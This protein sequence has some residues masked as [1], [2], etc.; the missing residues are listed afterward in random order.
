ML[1]LEMSELLKPEKVI[2][3]SSPK[4]R[5]ELP[6]KYRFMRGVASLAQLIFEPD[7]KKERKTCKAMLKNKN[8]KFM[9]RSVNMLVNWERKTNSS[10]II[11]IHGD[12]DNTISIKRIKNISFCVKNGSHMMAITKGNELNKLINNILKE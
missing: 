1:A 3:I 10:N 4:N 8:K 5:N 6:F 11:H 2:I 7:S 9:K 12:N